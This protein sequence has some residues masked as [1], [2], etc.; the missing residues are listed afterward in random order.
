[1]DGA[2]AEAVRAVQRGASRADAAVLLGDI[3]AK[4]GL[5]GEA[6][7]RYREARSLAADRVDARLG[8]VKALFALA[9]PRAEEA[10]TLAEELLALAPDHGDALVA[11]ARGRA[12]A[13]DA[14]GAPTALPPGR[15]AARRQERGPGARGVPAGPKVR[16][17]AGGGTVPTRRRPRPAAP[18]RRSGGGLGEGD[19]DRA[20]RA[21]RAARTGPRAHRARLEAHLR[22]GTGLS[23]G[24]RRT[25]PRA[26]HPR[27]LPAPRLEPE[28]GLVARHLGTAAQRRHDLLRRGHH[29]FRRDPLEPAPARRAAPA[30]R[31]D[32][33]GRS[34]TRPG[35]AGASGRP[36]PARRDPRRAGRPHAARTRAAGAGPHRRRVGLGEELDARVALVP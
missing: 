7:E 18:L 17:R 15:S 11:A 16:P 29:H 22:L 9:G 31:E 24:H 35:H 3:F 28:D 13:G 32:H 2:A 10:R 5:H 33:R 20:R 30:D 27:R 4:R 1:M 36:T 14:A 34:G 8:E 25:A 6:L 23:H 26:R 21:L 12:A 19:A